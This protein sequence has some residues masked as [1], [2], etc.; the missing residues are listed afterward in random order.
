MIQ[1]GDEISLSAIYKFINSIR[2]EEELP[3]QWKKSIIVQ[4]KKMVTKVSVVIVRYHS[5]Q[6]RISLSQC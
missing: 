6:L 1:A 2:N 3:D 4:I 5:Y